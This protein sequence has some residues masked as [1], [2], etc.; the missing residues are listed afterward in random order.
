MK[1]RTSTLTILVLL[2]GV[3]AACKTSSANTITLSEQDAGKTVELKTG[4]T[5]VVSLEGNPTTGFNWIPAAQD[6]MLLEQAGDAEFIPANDQLGSPG[7]IL[8][9]FNATTKGQTNLHLDYK[10][11]FEENVSPEK[12]F[13]VTVIVK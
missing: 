1:A 3:L 5:L 10:R 13:D 7:K 2:V 6:P 9:K 4:D 8:L 11:S 12:T